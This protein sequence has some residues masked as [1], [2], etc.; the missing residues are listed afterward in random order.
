M[1]P[2]PESVDPGH[3]PPREIDELLELR[4]IAKL[5]TVD[6]RGRPHLVAMWYRRDGDAILMP[7]SRLTKKIRNL[8]RSAYA[9]VLIDQN[10]SGLDLRGVHIRGRVELVEGRQAHELNRLVHLRY[11]TEHALKLPPVAEYLGE[12]DDVTIRIHMERVTSWNLAAREV[13]RAVLEAGEF[14]PLDA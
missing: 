13:G 4:L 2:T 3:L 6:E 1:P 8:R 11:V 5:A 14:Q 7:T 9:A 10:R 12:G